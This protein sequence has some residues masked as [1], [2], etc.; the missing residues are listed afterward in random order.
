MSGLFFHIH[1]TESKI[2]GE[3]S[4]S[5]SSTQPGRWKA[6]ALGLKFST[7]LVTV[8]LLFKIYES[9]NSHFTLP[10]FEFKSG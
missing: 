5:P 8:I 9:A 6:I 10:R 7:A 2:T 4:L 1:L 3:V